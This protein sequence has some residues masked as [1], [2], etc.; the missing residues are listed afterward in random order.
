MTEKSIEHWTDDDELLSKFVL[1]QLS[2]AEE[3][4]LSSHLRS[5]TTCR[6]A[7]DDEVRIVAG[8]RHAGRAELKQQLGSLLA[9]NKQQAVTDVPRRI[10]DGRVPWTRVASL[11]AVLAIIVAVGVYNN[12]FGLNYRNPTTQH[13]I[14]QEQPIRRAEPEKK[15][16]APASEPDK[17]IAQIDHTN[18]ASGSQ[19]KS[20]V[21]VEP[22]KEKSEAHAP[23]KD[24]E[25][26]QSLAPSPAQNSRDEIAVGKIQKSEYRVN[27]SDQSSKGGE[28]EFWVE[29]RIIPPGGADSGTM[30][31]G[32]SVERQDQMRV[33]AAPRSGLKKESEQLPRN[34]VQHTRIEFSLDQRP[35]SSLPQSLQNRQM[36]NAGTVQTLIKNREDTVQLTLYLESPLPDSELRTADVR[37]V[38]DD[39]LVLSLQNR[40]IGYRL[41]PAVQSQVNMKLRR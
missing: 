38:G 23:D 5:C 11:A 41:P 20:M 10:F 39:S 24:K 21:R 29:G 36:Q 25:L 33:A 22:L 1:H 15:Q 13:E 16:G 31:N 35:L 32:P 19:G 40:Q 4:L 14:V 8:I 7:V 27:L 34:S 37:V 3:R 18:E 26:R 12:W 28:Q 30:Q 17:T 6:A 2:A 9:R